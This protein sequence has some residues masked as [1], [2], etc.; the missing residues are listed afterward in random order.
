VND[1]NSGLSLRKI[2]TPPSALPAPQ[3]GDFDSPLYA[4][5]RG[6]GRGQ[7]KAL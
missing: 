6:W 3:G 4:V 2:I 5:G 1:N 7:A